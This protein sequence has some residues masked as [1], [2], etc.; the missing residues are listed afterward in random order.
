MATN[1]TGRIIA[2]VLV[3]VSALACASDDT[4]EDRSALEEKMEVLRIEGDF[5]SAAELAAEIVEI[6]RADSLVADYEVQDAERVLETMRFASAL[7]EE[8]R[9]LLARADSLA[10]EGEVLWGAGRFSDGAEMLERELGLRRRVLGPDH[11]EVAT[12]LNNL[13][14]LT[15][16][17]GDLPGAEALFKESLKL[18]RAALGEGHPE[19]ALAINNAASLRY[20]QGDY[21]AAAALLQE[22]LGLLIAA[23][24]E[25]D[26]V[27]V[28]CLLNLAGVRRASGD[29]AGAEPLYR[30]VLAVRRGEFG[31]DSLEAAEAMNALA[32]VLKDRGDYAA[33]EPLYKAGLAVR[34]RRLSEGHPAI[35]QSVNNLAA[36]LYS[37]GSYGEAE[38]LFREALAL[39]RSTLG[40]E[41]PD[42]GQSLNNLAATLY[43]Q[44]NYVGAEPLYEQALAMRRRLFGGE[45]PIVA[46]SLYNLGVLQKAKGDLAAALATLT[47]ALEMRIALLGG[48]H[49]DTATNLFALA[50]VRYLTGDYSAADSLYR[51]S[52]DIRRSVLGQEHPRV[53]ATLHR[54]GVSL[55]AG[56]DYDGAEPVLERACA[57]YDAARLRAGTGVSRATFLDSPYA[58]L[59]EVK[60]GLGK[61]DEAWP[62]AEKALAR[63]LTDLFTEASVRDLSVIE[64]AREESLRSALANREA[65]FSAYRLSGASEDSVVAR[66]SAALARTRFLEAEADWSAFQREMSERHPVTGGSA[67]GLSEVQRALDPETAIVGWIDVEHGSGTQESWGYVVRDDGPVFWVH[68]RP[69]EGSG[70]TTRDAFAAFAGELSDPESTELGIRLD[71]TELWKARF[72]PLMEALDGVRN[73]V[74]I[75]S[76]PS[77]GV[78]L[79]A[80]VTDAGVPLGESCSM[81]YVPSCT[82]YAWLE[83]R[84]ARVSG[85]HGSL[86]LGDPPFLGKLPR[87]EGS[88]DE[89]LAIEEV[90]NDPLVLLGP[91]ASETALE[92][93]SDSGRLGELSLVHLAT[94]AHVDDRV[95]GLSSLVLSQ[96][97]LPDPV[98]A[99]A[100]GRRVC[101]G[102]LTAREIVR[103]WNLSADLVTLSA[104]ETAL[105]REAGG[106]GYIGLSHAFMQAGAHSMLVSLWKVEDRATSMLMRRFYANVFGSEAAPMAKADALRE[107]KLWLRDYTDAAGRRPY[108]HPFYWSAFVLIGDRS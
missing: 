50:E 86:L 68:L 91:D 72:A 18:K 19:V 7:P 28:S 30:K 44:D 41:H 55:K 13:A 40:D 89:V 51:C 80:L 4:S 1:A 34:R 104:C 62:A 95:P 102:V 56:G 75:P 85:R 47:E 3:S 53:A 8:A 59:A 58:D 11:P 79:E 14:A 27:T 100:E 67:L 90:V 74:V 64:S 10:R 42:V 45:H 29:Y 69:P 21:E 15:G 24:G 65:E 60:L 81:S 25:N 52:L 48:R 20:S 96:E 63:T 97:D 93:L 35:A 22:A 12:T 87:L 54:L 71:A 6:V 105:G 108:H 83:S 2:V 94:H 84:D 57:V 101:D 23:F 38:P 16:A 103:G 61:T 92:E 106:E 73:L 32:A 37:Q 9:T 31:D 66:A 98:V 78:P 88:R 107:A 46:S 77:L 39:R 5:S 99:A 33:A 36:F 26:A 82:L 49:P 17:G 70:S 43:A 76:G